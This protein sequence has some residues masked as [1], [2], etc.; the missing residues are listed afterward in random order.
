MF[1][2]KKVM[3]LATT[4]NMI[5]QFMLPHI[6]HLQEN[7][8]TVEVVCAKTG[9]WFDEL[10]E[11]HNLVVHEIN[12]AR[13]PLKPSNFK[14]YKKLKQLQKERNFDLVYCQQP[15]GG[16]MGRLVGKKFKIPVIYTAH[17]FHF[18]KGCS[19]K[20]KMIYKTVEKWLSKFTD[21]LIT[22]NDED[23][24]AAKKMKAKHVA[25]ISGIGMEFNKYQPLTESRTEIRKSLNLNENDFVIVTVAE[26]I[27]RKNY[28]T[29]LKTIKELK[30]RNV[31]VKFIICGRGQEEENIKSQ[32]QELGIE[33]N[34][35]LLGFRKDINRILTASDMF[36]LAS[37]QEGL[38][39]S[40]IEAMSYGLP[41]VVSNVRGNRDLIADGKGGF[42]VE[43]TN[44]A[45][46]ADKI[47]VIMKNEEMKHKFEE[48]NKLESKKYTIKSVIAEL[49]EI[50]KWI[51]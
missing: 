21:V 31:N 4:D 23:Y 46:F 36:M 2:N 29:M 27:K 33:E 19:F 35:L 14:S 51:E 38:T 15:V 13:N 20:N 17:G 9:F 18:F 40:V 30:N 37:F 26:F 22:I 16:L 7:G 47:E 11:K 32:I 8:N 44:A 43:T 41:C 49:E 28:D 48:F 12:F 50:Y 34:V 10:K 6:R 3:M 5:W 42:V 39:L 1:T 25:K 24:E 45:M